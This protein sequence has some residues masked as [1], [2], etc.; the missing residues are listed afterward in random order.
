MPHP[1]VLSALLPARRCHP[2]WCFPL[3]LGGDGVWHPARAS[4]DLSIFPTRGVG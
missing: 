4:A 2:G 1:D 3:I